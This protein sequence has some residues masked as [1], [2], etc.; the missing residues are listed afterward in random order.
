MKKNY[1][2][3]VTAITEY[4]GKVL[5]G[6]KIKK[7]GHP[8]SEAWHIPGGRVE[9]GETEKQALVREMLEETGIKIEVK[10]FLDEHIIPNVNFKV[11]WYLCGPLTF[12]LKA[13][14]DLT[15]VKYIPK[16]EVS[17]I[18]NTEAVLLW[19]PKVKE[20]FEA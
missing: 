14:S 3:I 17:K 15:D 19:P 20:Y 8:L 7:P 13:G 11:R 10:R 9:K 4:N 12:E 18:C 1:K 5:I 6:K 16:S 2:I